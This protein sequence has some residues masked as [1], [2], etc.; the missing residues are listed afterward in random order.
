MGE[1]ADRNEKCQHCY[2]VKECML[3]SVMSD[4]CGGPWKDEMERTDFI[5]EHILGIKK[6]KA[7]KPD[8]KCSKDNIIQ[9]K[10]F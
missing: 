10:T 5:R 9:K 2:Y 3:T 8:S 7:K 6:E 1:L 4:R